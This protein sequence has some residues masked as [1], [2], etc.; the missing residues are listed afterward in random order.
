MSGLTHLSR[1]LPPPSLPSLGAFSLLLTPL[2]TACPQ[3]PQSFLLPEMSAVPLVRSPPTLLSSTW[4]VW[5]SQ[6]VALGAGLLSYFWLC[7]ACREKSLHHVSGFHMSHR[8]VS[9]GMY[10][11]K[12][13]FP[14]DRGKSRA[15]L[16]QPVLRKHASWHKCC[17]EVW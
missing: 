13:S 11:H 15:S 17:W 12:V 6:A 7:M 2:L 5:T 8:C 9:T 14:S 3:S 16:T 10:P 1:V 4:G